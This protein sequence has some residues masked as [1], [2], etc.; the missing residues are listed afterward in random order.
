MLKLEKWRE[1]LKSLAV[2]I[3]LMTLICLCI[4]YILSFSGAENFE[5][6]K[7]DME[8]VSNE[9][10]RYQYLDYWDPSL[11]SPSFIG[12]SDKSA[13]NNIGFY[14]LGGEHAQI[15]RSVYP[16]L[17]KLF[18]K[19]STVTPMDSG[20]GEKLFLSLLKGNYIYLSYACDL[21]TS[22]LLSMSGDIPTFESNT[23][24]YIRE[25][26]IVPKEY[27]ANKTIADPSGNLKQITVYSFYAV[28]KDGDGHY[29]RYDTDFLPTKPDDIAFHTNFYSTYTEIEN[30]LI[31]EFAHLLKQDDFLQKNNFS[32]KV[33]DTTVIPLEGAS[34]LSSLVFAESRAVS[35]SDTNPF[36]EFFYINP[37]KVSSY[38]DDHGILYYFDEGKTITLNQNGLLRYTS[39]ETD[40]ISL[41]MLFDWSTGEEEYDVFDYFGASFLVSRELQKT[42]PQANCKLYISGVYYDG[43]ELTICFGYATA[44]FPLYFDG[45]ADMIRLTFSGDTL[46]EASYRFRTVHTTAYVTELS[47]FLW[48]LRSY[49]TQTDTRHRYIYGYYFSKEQNRVGAEILKVT[50]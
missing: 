45:D 22:L 5:F 31:Y 34:Y 49:L 29:Y 43:T 50:E 1:R 6:S 37:E 25:L 40:G 17:E 41:E 27:L 8:A 4:I 42:Y 12:F 47:D 23:G 18:G 36:L 39:P 35:V 2:G 32:K 44:G 21:P 7:E 30:H 13:G 26:L 20:A 16:F 15:Y 48:T 33:T 14:T 19:E 38:T 28:A 9:S 11:V 24:E 10:I 3:L 46:K